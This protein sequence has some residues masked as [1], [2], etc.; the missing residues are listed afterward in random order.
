VSI[1]EKPSTQWIEKDNFNSS[2]MALFWICR[3]CGEN[4]IIGNAEL[5][6]MRNLGDLLKGKKKRKKLAASF[7]AS[8]V[9][10]SCPPDNAS[11]GTRNGAAKEDAIR[12]KTVFKLPSR[13]GLSLGPYC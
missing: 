13:G 3:A 4:N 7:A 6:H 2:F 11:S 10:P 1:R 12:G 9:R 5:A 8:P